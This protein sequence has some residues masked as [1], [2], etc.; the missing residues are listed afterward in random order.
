MSSATPENQPV[1]ENAQ[2]EYNVLSFASSFGLHV[3]QTDAVK[4]LHNTQFDEV[5]KTPTLQ[6]NRP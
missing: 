5:D 4:R 6:I 3:C 1:V 2:R